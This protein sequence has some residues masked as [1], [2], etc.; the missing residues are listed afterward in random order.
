MT[1][2][3]DAFDPADD[4]FGA[5]SAIEKGQKALNDAVAKAQ[6]KISE[7]A[8]VAQDALRKHA[9]SLGEY[10]KGYRETAGETFDDAQR[11]VVDAVNERPLVAVLIGFAVGLVFGVLLSSRSK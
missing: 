4:G 3:D 9:D 10:T 7:Q 5:A 1:A 6:A 8:K 2:D 11:Y